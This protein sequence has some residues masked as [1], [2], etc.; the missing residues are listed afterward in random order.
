M[1]DRYDRDELAEELLS[2]YVDGELDDPEVVAVEAR[3]AR[4][5]EW[6]HILDEVSAA[7]MAVRGLPQRDASPAFWLRVLTHVA[8]ADDREH[9]TVR[10]LRP[11]RR[12]R[13]GA[14]GA[15]AAAVLVGIA[16][17][18]PDHHG[19][20]SPNLRT[21]SDSHVATASATPSNPLTNLAPAAVPVNFQ[22]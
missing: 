5:G 2:A 18:A 7:R 14:V 12:A 6:R 21:V 8:E 9:A 13:W 4:D 22:P 19:T 10:R 17:A 1:S 11:V 20:V 16:V 15:A 3:L